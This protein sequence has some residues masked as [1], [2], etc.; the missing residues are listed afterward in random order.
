MQCAYIGSKF[1]GFF[2]VTY[3]L[4]SQLLKKQDLLLDSLQLCAKDSE[5]T[6]TITIK[7]WTDLFSGNIVEINLLHRQEIPSAYI[8][9]NVHLSCITPVR[10]IQKENSESC[11]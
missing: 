7:V 8:Q 2:W 4:V 9:S 11:W 10:Q 1:S 6:G 5:R 3:V